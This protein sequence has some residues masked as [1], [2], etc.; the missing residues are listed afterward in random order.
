LVPAVVVF[1]FA[2]PILLRMTGEKETDHGKHIELALVTGSLAE[3]QPHPLFRWCLLALGGRAYPDAAPAMAAIL[4]ALALGARAWLTAGLL[5]TARELSPWTLTGL[6]LALAVAMPL[7]NWWKF[8]DIYLGQPAPNVWHN[9]TT[10]LASPLAL[11]VF[12]LSVR[13][14]EDVR[15]RI[16]AAAGVTMAVS[17]L[18]K[19]NYLLA[20][21]P[22][23]FV[24]LLG[25]LIRDARAGRLT[26]DGAA[27]RMLL[28]F[29]LPAAVVGWQYVIM[30]PA[31]AGAPRVIFE[32]LVIWTMFTKSIPLSILLGIAFPIAVVA[33]S[34]R[35]LPGD[36]GMW[37]AW[38]P[39]I[40][41]LLEYALLAESG[42]RFNHANLG[43]GMILC[44]G[45]LFV[46][47]CEFLLRQPFRLPQWLAL[48]V[49]GLQV[50]SGCVFLV[51]SLQ[52]PS[53]S[54]LF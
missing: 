39:M 31:Y 28:A 49:L 50:A 45:V 52:E 19:P 8:P 25:K 10:I 54:H 32:P 44:S 18:A 11:A 46:A 36:R 38:L 17:L 5:A 34:P 20:F 6:C 40:V 42:K 33:T 47:S 22:C 4:L 1:L 15:W 43:W 7:P 35:A 3:P 24:L 51:R 12:L 26:P 2:L 21:G 14:L 53:Q 23:F 29:A 37:L 41:S 27:A 13:A 48:S 9:P 16:F 30:Y